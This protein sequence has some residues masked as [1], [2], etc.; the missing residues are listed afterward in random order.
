MEK[1]NRK[2]NTNTNKHIEFIQIRNH[3]VN[4]ILIEGQLYELQ[5]LFT[6]LYVFGS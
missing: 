5:I 1:S 6:K 3:Y 4:E 2:A